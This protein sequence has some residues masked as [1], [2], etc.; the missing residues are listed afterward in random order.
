MGDEEVPSEKDRRSHNQLG[1]STI[2]TYYAYNDCNR[3]SGD[4]KPFET[5]DLQ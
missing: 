3:E 4:R 2:Q 5:S 1:F